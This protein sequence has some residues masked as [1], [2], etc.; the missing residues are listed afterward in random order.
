M[1]RGVGKVVLDVRRGLGPRAAFHYTMPVLATSDHAIKRDPNMVAAGVRAVVKT[2]QALKRDPSLATRVGKALFP[3]AEAAL[4]ADVIARDLPYYTISEAAVDGL[5]RFAQAS[6]LA[7][8]SVS[9][10]QV[11][12]LEFRH[13]WTA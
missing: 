7:R 1:R 11:V 13:L 5:S 10:N 6:G 9:Y 12:A 3:P 4:I 2:Q 8:R